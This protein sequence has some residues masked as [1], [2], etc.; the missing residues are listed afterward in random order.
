LK[1][2]L[3]RGC[4]RV[5]GQ[6]VEPLEEQPRSREREELLDHL[7]RC[8]QCT[9]EYEEP[10]RLYGLMSSDSVTLLLAEVSVG[11]KRNVRRALRPSGTISSLPRLLPEILIPVLAAAALLMIILWPR[12][13]TVEFSI[14]VAE[15]IED[16]DIAGFVLAGTVDEQI[17]RE[18]V[19]IEDHL[20]P[21]YEEAIDELTREE[22]DE[23]IIAL[24][25]EYRAGT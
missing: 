14:P 3:I 23:L 12:N 22:E 4:A 25:R 20:L 6:K 9:A 15:L 13:G 19:L 17:M 5:R 1:E 16:E 10:T 24:Q 2:L 7:S 8:T 11:M 21:G 18:L